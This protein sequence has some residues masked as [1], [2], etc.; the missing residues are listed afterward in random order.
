MRSGRL[1]HPVMLQQKTETRGTSGGV[2]TTWTDV[3]Q[4]WAG[5]EPLS[6]K[7][8]LS[9]RQI[10]NEVQVRVVIRHYPG[11]DASWRLKQ[12]SVSPNLIYTIDSVINHDMK[13][14]MVTL[15]CRQGVING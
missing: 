13:N 11:L 7:E 8:I 6:G 12:L 5:I 15:M 2:S 9:A 10:Q 1:R 3:E 4:I 14:R